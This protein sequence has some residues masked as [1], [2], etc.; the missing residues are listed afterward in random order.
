MYQIGVFSGDQAV[1]NLLQTVTLSKYPLKLYKYLS[2]M[3]L[4]QEADSGNILSDI[5][6][7][8]IQHMRDGITFA[9][10]I[11]EKDRHVRLI[12]IASATNE[13]SCIFETEPTYLLL[14][15]F[16]NIQ[17]NHAIEKAMAQLQKSEKQFLALYFRDKFMRIPLQEIFYIQSDRRYLII[18]WN[19]EI[20]TVMMKMSEMMEKL[21]DYFVRCHQSYVVNICKIMRFEKN[22]ILLEN[23][24]SIAVSRNRLEA[25]RDAIKKYYILK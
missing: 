7:L 9:K 25:A 24:I 14:K 17:L 5:L 13:L 2:K 16:S 6:L 20:S 15:P 21:P 23:G 3:E 22:Q 18:Y 19:N 10:N 4:E 12:F 1:W 8:D 11:Q